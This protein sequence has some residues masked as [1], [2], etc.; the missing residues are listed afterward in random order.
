[1][2]ATADST[3]TKLTGTYSVNGGCANGVS[4]NISGQLY[5]SLT[6]TY[7]GT[8]ASGNTAA[9]LSLLLAQQAQGTGDGRS[10]VT[11]TAQFT[12]FPCFT[13]GTLA[14]PSGFVRGSAVTLTFATDDANGATLLLAGTFDPAADQLQ[15][16]TVEVQGGACAGSYGTPTLTRSAS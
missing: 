11:G 3:L 2:E 15:L 8:S 14:T 1:M 16:S 6:G 4:G 13:Q 5:A 10:L 12:G 7:A 9:T